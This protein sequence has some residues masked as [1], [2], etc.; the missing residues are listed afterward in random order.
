MRQSTDA[1]D[2]ASAQSRY[3]VV[4]GEGYSRQQAAGSRQQAAGSRQQAAG[5]RQQAGDRDALARDG[6]LRAS[7]E[8]RDG[9]D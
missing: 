1:S 6:R 7:Y 8:G 2:V 9:G 3:G 5:S 4:G